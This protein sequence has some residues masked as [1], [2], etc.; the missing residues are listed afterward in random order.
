MA[1]HTNRPACFW[2]DFASKPS[3]EIIDHAQDHCMYAVTELFDENGEGWNFSLQLLLCGPQPRPYWFEMPA[4]FS[5]TG[6]WLP[7]TYLSV[8]PDVEDIQQVLAGPVP[9]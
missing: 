4:D 8:S 6:S 9:A 7:G 3:T 1:T 5:V 2:Y